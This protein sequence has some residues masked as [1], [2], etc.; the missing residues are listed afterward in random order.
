MRLCWH[1]RP[2]LW[3]LQHHNDHDQP[4][5][6]HNDV[7]FLQLVQYIRDVNVHVDHHHDYHHHDGH[8]EQQHHHQQHI[9]CDEHQ[10]DRHNHDHQHQLDHID[11]QRHEHEYDII[12]DHIEHI[13]RDVHQYVQ[14]LERHGN[15]DQF[16]HLIRNDNDK[17]DIFVKHQHHEHIHE[18]HECLGHF[19]NK[20]EHNQHFNFK[21]NRH[22]LND[23]FDHHHHHVQHQFLS[24]EDSF[25]HN[26]DH[27]S[28]SWRR[29]SRSNN[30]CCLA[31]TEHCRGRDHHHTG[32]STGCAERQLQACTWGHDVCRGFLRRPSLLA[33]FAKQ[34]RRCLRGGCSAGRCPVHAGEALGRRVSAVG[35]CDRRRQLH[36]EGPGRC[37]VGV[38]G[39]CQC[40]SDQVAE[41]GRGWVDSHRQHRPRAGRVR[42]GRWGE[43]HGALCA[44]SGSFASADACANHGKAVGA[45]GRDCGPGR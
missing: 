12:D 26:D 20:H 1:V 5:I 38:W 18:Y 42:R 31:S 15:H 9:V 23:H 35:R 39:V 36:R 40:S 2:H 45:G 4:D 27:S 44:S 43:R 17:H 14:H 19:R 25:R 7:I 21:Q 41:L 24:H 8:H 3:V 16:V 13:E 29:R 22:K 11:D 6:N 30:H 33:G 28:R 34:P 10:F 37:C 32:C